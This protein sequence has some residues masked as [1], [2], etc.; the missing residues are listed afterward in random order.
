MVTISTYTLYPL[1]LNAWTISMQYLTIPFSSFSGEDFQKSYI[2]FSIFKL[3][4]LFFPNVGVTILLR[5]FNNTYC[6]D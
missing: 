1:L 2:K 4:L 3:F 6:K 5:N